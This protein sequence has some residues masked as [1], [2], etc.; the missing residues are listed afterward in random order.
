[1]EVNVIIVEDEVHSGEMLK[2]MVARIRPQWNIKALLQS[3]SETVHWLKNNEIPH[4]I[5]LDIELADGNCFS[6]FEQ[7]YVE[8]GIIF[9]T[10]YNEFA[11]KA[12]KLNSIDYLLKPIKEAELLQAIDK[13]EKAMSHFENSV[14]PSI[15]YRQLVNTIRSSQGEYR[16]RFIISKRE[17]FFKLPVDDIAYFNFENRIT[18]AVTFDNK[19]HVLNQSLDK[20]EQELDPKCFF[21]TNRQTIVNIEAIDRFEVYFSGKLVVK[22]INNLNDKII[23]SRVKASHFKDWMNQ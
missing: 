17:S 21:R 14:K 13:F 18:Y 3:V 7:V 4:V 22:L 16:Q 11:L 5:F 9:T 15:D 20:I 1:M 12:F 6:I 2:N 23:V 19:Q 8:S 10:A